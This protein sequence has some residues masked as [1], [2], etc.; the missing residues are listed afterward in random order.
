[1]L[2]LSWLMLVVVARP[3][4]KLEN[5]GNAQRNTAIF[6]WRVYIVEA[7]FD[8]IVLLLML[9]PISKNRNPINKDK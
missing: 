2:T 5:E 4:E 3:D 9:R 8:Y 6:P 7:T 1:M